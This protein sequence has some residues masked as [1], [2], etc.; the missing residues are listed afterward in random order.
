MKR[1]GAGIVSGS[2]SD[3][4]RVCV[5]VNRIGSHCI[6]LLYNGKMRAGTAASLVKA[7]KDLQRRVKEVKARKFAI[8]SL[9]SAPT[10]FLIGSIRVCMVT[11]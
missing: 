4:Y 2:S 1:N 5:P 8:E 10:C 6:A 3:S 7:Y 9:T 11:G